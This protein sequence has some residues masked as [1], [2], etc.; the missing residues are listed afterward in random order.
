MKS[1]RLNQWL[2]LAANFGVIAGILLLAY[3][4]RQNSE[5]LEAQARATRSEERREAYAPFIE[6]AGVRTAF[7]KAANGDATTPV[8]DALIDVVWIN[9]FNVW[10]ASWVEYQYGHSSLDDISVVGWKHDF[11]NMPRMK[12]VWEAR[13]FR[14]RHDFVE[15]VEANIVAD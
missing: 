9:V 2:S 4:I 12:E 13:K 10:E 7:F 5:V 15:W 1:D 14:V 11:H 3:E 6:N 8:E